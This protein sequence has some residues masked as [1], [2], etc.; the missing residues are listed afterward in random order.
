[1]KS[2]LSVPRI[3]GTALASVLGLSAAALVTGL[4]FPG[5]VA[6]HVVPALLYRPG[7]A[8]GVDPARS[9][10][11]DFGL[12]AGEEV[13]IRTEDGVELHGWWVPARGEACGALLFFHGNAGTIT[14]RAEVGRR[15]AASGHGTLLVDYRGYGL[16]GGSPSEEG[17]AEDARASW[18]HLREERGLAPGRIAVAGHSLGAAV[19]ARLAPEVAPGAVVLTGA[20]TSVPDLAADIYRWLPDGLFRGWPTERYEVLDAVG[21]IGAPVL[22]ARGGLDRLVP[23]AQ[24]RRVFEAAGGRGEWYEAPTAGHGDL[25]LDEAFWERLRAFLDDALGCGRA[26]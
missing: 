8:G 15:S 11:D 4:V 9:G 23:R 24:T 21:D 2:E 18:R 6:R 7:V 5:L 13:R 22:V 14:S 26:P 16:S 1:M 19:A 3:V 10:P 17:L 12:P 25:W 20:F